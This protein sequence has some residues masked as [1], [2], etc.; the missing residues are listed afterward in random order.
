MFYTTF[1]PFFL[2]FQRSNYRDCLPEMK[3]TCS[4]SLTFWTMRL[5]WRL[6]L[7]RGW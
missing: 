7:F 3:T 6:N 4:H 5:K 2:Q 1:C